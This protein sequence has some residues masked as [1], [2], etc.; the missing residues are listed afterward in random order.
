MEALDPNVAEHIKGY[1]HVHVRVATGELNGRDISMR[2]AGYHYANIEDFVLQHG[3]VFDRW[4][5]RQDRYMAG[6]PRYCFDNA[7]RA[8]YRSRGKLTY[9]EGYALGSVMPVH[10]A[11]C[12]DEDGGIVD[13]TWCGDKKPEGLWDNP[14]RGEAYLGVPFD[15][16]TVR[17]ARS[18]DNCSVLDQW[19]NH[20]PLLREPFQSVALPG[21]G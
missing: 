15:L 19:H 12:V 21:S 6:T 18:K 4:S 7:Y 13:P 14:E 20:W 1:L 16:A 5:P 2:R 17:A 10:H 3:T 11:W 8:T 9:V